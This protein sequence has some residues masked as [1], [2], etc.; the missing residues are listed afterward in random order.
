MIYK[1]LV[2]AIMDA[3]NAFGKD[4]EIEHWKKIEYKGKY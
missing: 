4:P 1:Y 2:D 3:L